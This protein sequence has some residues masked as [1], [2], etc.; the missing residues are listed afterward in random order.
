[1]AARGSPDPSDSS[2]DGIVWAFSTGLQVSLPYSLL[3][4]I[5]AKP[6]AS[7]YRES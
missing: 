1:M 2:A 4:C 6:R 5:V 3:G 7:A